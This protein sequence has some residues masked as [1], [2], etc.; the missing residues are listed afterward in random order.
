DLPGDMQA[1]IE[2]PIF[3]RVDGYMSKRNV[4][5]GDVVKA[6]QVMAEIETPELDQ[7]LLQAR[8]TLSNIQSSL[9][10]LQANITLAQANLKM[11]ETTFN[12]W[13]ILQAKGAIS[14][15]DFD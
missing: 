6:G 4:D 11:A 1:L 14:R 12:R 5:I 7:Q 10:E 9:K 15:Q 8:A 2:S 13:K 3:P